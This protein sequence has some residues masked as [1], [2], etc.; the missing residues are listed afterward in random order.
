MS[1]YYKISV[2]N[3]YN[4]EKIIISIHYYEEGFEVYKRMADD[5]FELI[6]LGTW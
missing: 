6:E 1:T 3:I 4:N 5:C 2:W